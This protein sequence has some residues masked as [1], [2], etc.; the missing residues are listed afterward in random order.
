VNA[1]ASAWSDNRRKKGTRASQLTASPKQ[2]HMFASR[3]DSDRMTVSL[4]STG[5]LG[6][7]AY[8]SAEKIRIRKAISSMPMTEAKAGESREP[9]RPATKTAEVT[10]KLPRVPTMLV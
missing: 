6:P 8:K 1:S 7:E 2:P 5:A 9:S 4:V 10:L 3:C